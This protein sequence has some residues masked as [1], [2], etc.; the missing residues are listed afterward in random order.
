MPF[1]STTDAA[2]G[3]AAPTFRSWP[4]VKAAVTTNFST[5]YTSGMQPLDL[6]KSIFILDKY[7]DKPITS[8]SFRHPISN[9]H[10]ESLLDF[11]S[12]FWLA[13]IAIVEEEIRGRIRGGGAG[14]GR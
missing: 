1:P 11:K 9:N 14:G 7:K 8:L 13:V 10:D 6:A 5:H 3:A 2:A 4:K 12:A